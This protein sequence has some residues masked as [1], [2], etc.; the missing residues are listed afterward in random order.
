MEIQTTI[1]WTQK[2]CEG[3]EGVEVRSFDVAAS[4]RGQGRKGAIYA[5]RYLVSFDNGRKDKI[6]EAI[7]AKR[8]ILSKTVHRQEKAAYTR[9][10]KAISRG[11]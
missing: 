2:I 8:E 7:T 3:I 4:G 11:E 6:I 5:S 1:I 10:M 9:L